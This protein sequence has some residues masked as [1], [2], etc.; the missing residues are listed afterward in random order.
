M[1][2]L[3]NYEL[4]DA[5]LAEMTLAVDDDGLAVEAAVDNWMEEHPETWQSWLPTEA[6]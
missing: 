5:D 1:Q 3:E 6:P 4:A 2:V